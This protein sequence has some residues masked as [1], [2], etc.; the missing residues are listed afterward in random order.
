MGFL[1][2]VLSNIKEHLGQHKN[3]LNDAIDTLNTN[4]H[5]GKKGF[6]EAIGSVVAGVGR[7]NKAVEQSNN[8]VKNP[9]DELLKFTKHD[10]KLIRDL[11]SV[12]VDNIQENKEA[13]HV[14]KMH[15]AVNESLD[16][17]RQQADKFI[18]SLDGQ[19]ENI[20]NL[21][22]KL[23]DTVN[24]VV[25]CIKHERERLSKLAEKESA[26]LEALKTGNKTKLDELKGV[27][28]REIDRQIKVIVRKLRELVQ[29]ILDE[30]VKVHDKLVDFA[31]SLD[32]WMKNSNRILDLAAANTKKVLDEVDGKAT[33]NNKADLQQAIK[34]VGMDFKEK[35]SELDKWKKAGTEAV[36][37]AKE[38]CTEIVGK[39]NGQEGEKT[40]G[41]K[42]GVKDAADTLRAKADELREKAYKAKEQ[43]TEWVRQAIGAVGVMD[44]AL[45]DELGTVRNQIKTR[46][47]AYVEQKLSHQIRKAL[48]GMTDII[49]KD[50]NGGLLGSIVQGVKGNVSGIE[51]KLATAAK[52]M[53]TKM[54]D[55]PKGAV[56]QYIDWYVDQNKETH[57]QLQTKGI[58]KVKR[59]INDYL[60]NVIQQAMSHAAEASS[61]KSAVNLDNLSEN[62][63]TFAQQIVKSIGTIRAADLVKQ[64]EGDLKSNSVLEDRSSTTNH[65]LEYALE[66][67]VAAVSAMSTNFAMQLRSL[68]E[69]SSISNLQSA[70]EKVKGLGGSLQTALITPGSSTLG[71]Q[72]DDSI[73]EILKGQLP[74]MSG[75]VDVHSA[76]ALLTYRTHVNTS[77]GNPEGHV[78]T[79]IN[80]IQSQGLSTLTDVV[81]A[82]GDER[83]IGTQTFN[84]L[85]ATVDSSLDQFTSG[86]KNLVKKENTGTDRDSIDAYL[87]E[88]NKMLSNTDQFTLTADEMSSHNSLKGLALI[89]SQLEGLMTSSVD[90]LNR[91]L[92][93]LCSAIRRDGGTLKD[94]LENLRTEKV[95]KELKAIKTNIEHLIEGELKNA[96]DGTYK[97]L[98]TQADTAGRQIIGQL[99]DFVN[100]QTD[101]TLCAVNRQ[102]QKNFI[103]SIRDL[104]T[105]FA[106]KAEKELM[107]L[108]QAITNDLDKGHKGFMKTFDSK[109]VKRFEAIKDVSTKFSPPQNSP[110]SQAA[111]TLHRAFRRLFL[112]LANQ[113]DFIPDKQKIMPWQ[114]AFVTLLDGLKASEYFDPKFHSNLE[115]LKLKVNEFDPHVFGEG[116]A[117][118]I[119]NALRD[120]LTPMITELD[121]A[122]ISVYDTET[123]DAYYQKNYARIFFTVITTLFHDL[124]HLID[125]CQFSWFSKEIN[126]ITLLGSLLNKCGY[127]VATNDK[128]CN[129]ELRN[130]SGMQGQHI[131]RNLAKVIGGANDNEHLQQCRDDKESED[132]QDKKQLPKTKFN[133]KDIL[134]CLA[135]HLEKYN[136]LRHSVAPRKASSP[137][138]VYEMLIWLTGLPYTR[139]HSDMVSV[140]ISALFEDRKKHRTEIADGIELTAVATQAMSLNAY[141][142]S[143]RYEN[144]TSAITQICTSSYDILTTVLGTGDAATHYASQ[145]CDNTFNLHYPSDAAA[146]LDMFLDILRRVLPPLRFLHSQCTLEAKYAGWSHCQYGKEIPTTKSHCNERP[147]DKA[148]C[149]ANNKVNCQPTSPLMSCLNDCLPG[150]LPHQL[151]SI[152]C[153][154][155]CM[156]CPATSKV[157]MPC[158]TP[159]GFRAFSGSTKTG[160]HLCE[161][162]GKFLSIADLTSLL[163]LLPKPPSSLPEHYQFA[164]SLVRRWNETGKVATI[165][166][167]FVKSI[168]G[169]TIHL[170]DAP[171]DFTDALCNAYGDARTNHKAN[172]PENHTADISSLS[173]RTSCSDKNHCAP[174]LQ[175]LYQDTY[176]YFAEQHANLYLSWAIYL[177][178]TLHRYL[179]ALLAAFQQIICKDWGCGR[180]MHPDSCKPGSHGSYKSPCQCKSIVTCKGVSATLYQYGF[181]FADAPVLY[182][183]NTRKKCHNFVQQLQKVIE[184]SYFSDLFKH[185]DNFLFTIR[186]PFIWT[187][188]ALWSLSLFYLICV[189]VGRL[190]VLHIRSHLRTPSSHKITAQSLLAAAQ[191]G[192]LA[193]ISY[194]QP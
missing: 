175:S 89:T 131:I 130:S 179:K 31:K 155:K 24:N 77:S 42:G 8:E 41:T 167:A 132:A 114:S 19:T 16:E 86:V 60:P 168:N 21:N 26:D 165:K 177:P 166:D 9:I 159:F 156:T 186:Q 94:Q 142:T 74:G 85:R 25:A 95:E 35:A 136:D 144:V 75:T 69:S 113:E 30:L 98:N 80:K 153:N 53:I 127:E 27:M 91:E 135:R 11:K 72:F 115:I 124:T 65:N 169:Q 12:Q 22:P 150:Q 6:N 146:C 40:P 1:S 125:R 194:L 122:Y 110:L 145:Y 29:L 90:S 48:E 38:K 183:F 164:V 163:C 134:A 178:W 70:M 28:N 13:E 117:P 14:E 64:I 162:L 148:T 170:H 140:T 184:S 121:R 10:G 191:V 59:S 138:S 23:R 56:H 107:P 43:V 55:E 181:T 46:L 67:V 92:S 108:P 3:T 17:C 105:A 101:N 4:K 152:G 97:F 78:P 81:A 50:D 172:N 120:G 84:R 192:R 32:A 76:S 157:G 82:D 7:Y 20:N 133:V 87:E 100:K 182:T 154:Y 51:T 15:R 83:T 149:Q 18:Q 2:G 34:K 54:M 171:N 119:L 143:I 96:I 103:T 174:Y 61:L 73:T 187:T 118:L 161:M 88:L 45:K 116:N 188:V 62:L 190:D 52:E 44:R 57:N 47:Q 147:A 5:R 160:K 193:K 106:K 39:L 109:F 66:I 99:H 102:A 139:V 111:E 37:L 180:C 185:C 126:S 36:R 158:L 71:T 104:L 58:E 49:A 129:G 128:E 173:M 151:A 176:Y 112:N 63:R 68:I 93:Y 141:P 189:M 123:W 33:P 79:A 137:C